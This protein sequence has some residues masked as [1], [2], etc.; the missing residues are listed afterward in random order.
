[1]AP[2]PTSLPAGAAPLTLPQ[3]TLRATF[4]DENNNQILEGG[5]SVGLRVEAT[6][7]G[8]DTLA[9]ASIVLS[10]T[11][12]LLDAFTTALASPLQL[13]PFRPGETKAT[14][15]QGR[16]PAISAP[17]RGE[18]TVSLILP[19]SAGAAGSASQTLVA[20]VRPDQGAT[21]QASGGV[22][23]PP[24]PPSTEAQ[25][26]NRYA[27][28]VGVD[29]YRDPWP[30]AAAFGTVTV[31]AVPDLLTQHGGMPPDQ[32]L[33]LKDEW[34]SRR[35]IEEA[36]VD[37]LPKRINRDSV[38]LVYFRGQALFDSGSGQVLLVPYDGGPYSSAGRLIYL[39]ALQQVLS[40]LQ[41]KL[42][43]LLMEAPVASFQG[44]AA[45]KQGKNARSVRSPNWQGT[46][47]AVP[48]GRQAAA[49]PL[50]GARG[51]GANS[52]QSGPTRLIQIVHS[53]AGPGEAGLLLSWLRGGA[54]ADRDGVLSVGEM[55]DSVK[56]TAT[57]HPPI[58]SNAPERKIPITGGR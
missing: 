1:V 8:T 10:G 46:L 9:S 13:G 16:M 52:P 50:K 55:L 18:L 35:D 29:R 58:P 22:G 57:I 28:V 38:V 44:P 23:A 41:A 47:A 26:A 27:I 30:Q 31:D 20:A 32:V 4:L 45:G 3:L 48:A 34:A 39:P 5:E 37:W 11:P 19:P 12:A 14:L 42:T 56:K 6:N 7:I 54:D 17:D 49:E 40:R 53:P 36:L 15:L 21:P 33:F 25:S 2:P 43:V 51:R 24:P